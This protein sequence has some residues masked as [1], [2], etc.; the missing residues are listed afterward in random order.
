MPAAA[1]AQGSTNGHRQGC[2]VA[3]GKV[4][5]TIVKRQRRSRSRDGDKDKDV[6]AEP[7]A[8]D[9]HTVPLSGQTFRPMSGRT[10]LSTRF[11]QSLHGWAQNGA[12][13]NYRTPG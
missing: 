5:K 12:T 10:H 6:D 11:P 13:T 1:E 8:F 7:P 3:G 4:H 9:A 2:H